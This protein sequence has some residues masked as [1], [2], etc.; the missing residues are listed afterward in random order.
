MPRDPGPAPGRS[1]WKWSRTGETRRVLL[2]AAREVFAERGFA[3]SSVADVVERAGS[4]VGSLYHHFGGKSEL[5]LALWEEWKD[6]QEKRAAEA[7]T[8]ARRAGETQPLA[9]FVAGAR[10]F[11]RGSWEGRAVGSLFVDKDGPPGFELLRRTRGHEWIRQNSL[12]LQAPDDAIGRVTVSVLTNVIGEAGREVMSSRTRREA[13]AI[14]DAAVVMIERLGV[15]VEDVE[16]TAEQAI[17][18]AEGP[19]VEVPQSGAGT[20]IAGA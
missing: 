11:L 3:E 19:A 18:P 7:V 15:L 5:F 4:S 1:A 12:L 8:A 6:S 16:P 2:D 10:G 9:L 14:V 13:Q 17:A 20:V